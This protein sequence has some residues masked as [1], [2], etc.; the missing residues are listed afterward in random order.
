MK[1][2]SRRQLNREI[3]IA[4]S[5]FKAVCSNSS[6]IERPVGISNPLTTPELVGTFLS[7]EEIPSE[8]ESYN[9]DHLPSESDANSDS[10]FET[11]YRYPTITS[12]LGNLSQYY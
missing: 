12:K 5:D 3:N 10:D 11:I 9:S 2:S 4:L 6:L 7:D 1:S 8:S